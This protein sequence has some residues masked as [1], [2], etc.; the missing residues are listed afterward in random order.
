MQGRDVAVFMSK[1]HF[2][3]DIERRN[4]RFV[5]YIPGAKEHEDDDKKKRRKFMRINMKTIK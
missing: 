4:R 3:I 2:Q 1:K 5:I